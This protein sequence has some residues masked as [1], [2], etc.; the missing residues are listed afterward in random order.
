MVNIWTFTKHTMAMLLQLFESILKMR[1]DSNKYF[2]FYIIFRRLIPDTLIYANKKTSGTQSV[3]TK[4][5]IKNI[6]KKITD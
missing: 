5:K 4:H 3:E 6:S 1:N 2:M